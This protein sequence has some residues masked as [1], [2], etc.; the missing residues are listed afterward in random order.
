MKRSTGGSFMPPT[1]LIVLSPS[2]F[3]VS[4]AR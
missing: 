2:R 3:A 4:A 1:E